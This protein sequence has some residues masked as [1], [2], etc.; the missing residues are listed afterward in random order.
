VAAGIGCVALA[1]VPGAVVGFLALLLV[2]LLLV[3]AL[4][5]VLELT[6]RRAGEAE[7][8]AAGLVWMAGNLG[9][10]VI[11][12]IVGLLV[13]HPTP[14]F[15]VTAVAAVVAVPGALALRPFI[16]ALRPVP[17]SSAG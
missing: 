10:L 4:P 11:A 6:E 3:P 12:S 15:L 2:G 5:I 17:L 7:G 13:D 14:A 9:G 16:A 8:T 1:V